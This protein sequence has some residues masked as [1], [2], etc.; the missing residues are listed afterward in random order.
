MLIKKECSSYAKRW[1]KMMTIIG[2]DCEIGERYWWMRY[3]YTINDTLR[4]LEE[5]EK[6]FPIEGE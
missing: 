3:S 4:F 2:E 1:K 6:E 5:I